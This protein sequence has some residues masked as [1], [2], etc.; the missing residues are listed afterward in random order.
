MRE[1]VFDTETTGFEPGEGRA[2]PREP[3]LDGHIVLADRPGLDAGDLDAHRQGLV[4]ELPLHEPQD[5]PDE[6]RRVLELGRVAVEGV[7]DER[8]EVGEVLAGG[9]VAGG[10]EG[11]G[12]VG[13]LQR[14]QVAADVGDGGEAER[15]AVGDLGGVDGHAPS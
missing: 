11:A 10:A 7:G 13:G 9:P 5:E 1:I 12:P 6:E 14:I 4:Q 2:E 8:G 15:A 3:F